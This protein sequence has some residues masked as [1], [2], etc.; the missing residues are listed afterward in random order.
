MH[1][2]GTLYL[3]RHGQASFGAADYDQLSDLGRRQCERL[4]AWFDAQGVAFDAV[5]TGTLRRHTQSRAAI[6]AGMDRQHEALALPGL[7][8]YDSLAVVHAL[9]PAALPTAMTRESVREHFRMLREG[10]RAWMDGRAQPQ[11]LP[12]H[13]AF[14]AGV[15]AALD[16]VRAH[17]AEGR[18]LVVSSGGPIS[19]ALGHVLGLGPEAVIDLNM[20]LRNS[21]VSELRVSPRRHTLVTFNTLPHLDGS[22]EH[23]GWITHA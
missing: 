17:H 21:A 7:N 15:V 22:P 18:V 2:M 4:G 19:V 10:L 6:A 11:G 12:T 1:G 14:T 5:L 3:V 16:H 13:A 20:H 9:Y 8:E 23:A